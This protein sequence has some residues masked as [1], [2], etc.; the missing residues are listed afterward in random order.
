VVAEEAG[1]RS[2]GARGRVK[3]P[4]THKNEQD[5]EGAER[6]SMT[7]RVMPVR[8]LPLAPSTALVPIMLALAILPFL[9]GPLLPGPPSPRF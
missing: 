3:K 8:S 2:H 6:L 5:G 1:Q 7:D 4:N 9:I